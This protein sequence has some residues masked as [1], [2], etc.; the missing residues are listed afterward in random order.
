MVNNIIKPENCLEVRVIEKL[1]LILQGTKL[2]V[3]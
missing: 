2:A 1:P 3:I